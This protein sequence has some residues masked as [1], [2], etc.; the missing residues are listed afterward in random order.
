[1][2]TTGPILYAR[3]EPLGDSRT[4][5]LAIDRCWRALEPHGADVVV[6]W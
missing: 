1:M 6:L 4:D 3:R 5:W 2:R